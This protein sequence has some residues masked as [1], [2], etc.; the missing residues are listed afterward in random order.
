[1]EKDD[2]LS[3]LLRDGPIQRTSGE[4]KKKTK[5]YIVKIDEAETL[6]LYYEISA[7][8]EKEALRIAA[9]GGERAKFL[10]ESEHG[11]ARR[12]PKI[13]RR[14]LETVK[15]EALESEYCLDFGTGLY[16]GLDYDKWPGDREEEKK[17]E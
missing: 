3:I 5:K 15:R 14:P 9:H 2:E 8:S 7:E 10:F 12:K 16:G 1:M 4:E 11:G 13:E 17:S 6:S